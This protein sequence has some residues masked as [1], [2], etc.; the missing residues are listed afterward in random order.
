[1]AITVKHK[2]ISA[3]PDAG[4]PNVVQPSNWNDT[5]EL[6][7][8]GTMA[9]QNANAVAITGG[10]MSGV[11][12]TGYI[13]TT[14]KAQPLGVAT[15]DAS[16]KVPTSQ[17]PMQ[18]DLNY[19]GTWNANT[20]TPTLVS[21]TGTKGYYYVVDVAGTTNLNG[22]TDWQIGDW[23]IFN[24]TIWQK[25]DNTD[26]VSSVNGQTGAVVLT[27]TNIAE[28]TNEYFTTARAR[29]SVSAGTGI[30]YDNGTG[31]ITNSAPDQTVAISD[32][33]G[34]D[35][36][37][38]Y[39]NFT[40]TN[41]APD[42]T[43]VLTGGT[44][45]STS[46][47]YPSFTVTN[48]APDQIVGLTGAGTTVVTGTY[49]NF[50][51][52]STDSKVGD[53]VGPT[54]ATDNAIARYDSTTGKLI[55]NSVVTVS[56]TGA[57][58]G[59]SH[60]TDLD[61]LDFDTTYATPLG[62]GQLG[63]N[64]NDTLGLGMIGGNVVQHIGEDTFF[65]IKASATITKGQ[66]CMFT[67]AVG[68]SGV[69]TAAPATA[70]PYA[71]AILGVAAEDIANN[72]FGLVQNTGTLKGVNTSAFLDGDVL[73]YN[74]AV[75]GGFTKTY[76]ASGP[77]ALVAAVAKSGSGGSGVLTVRVSFQTR[78]TGSTGIS[79]VQGN[80]TVVVTNT[81]PDQ[82]V[83]IT[84]AGGAVVTG[85]YPSFTVTTP[86]GTVTS[87]TGTSPIVS[88]GGA[89][90][91]ISMPAATGSV[92][93]YLTSTDWTTFNNKSNTVGT[94]TSVGGTGTVNGLTLTGT[95][96]SSGNLTLGG[97]LNLSSPPAIGNTTPN[98]VAGTVIQATNG[99]VVNSNTV[100]ASYTIPVG[101]S[102]MSA[103]PMTVASGQA[104]TVSS[105][106]RWVIL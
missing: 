27:T 90:P 85:T 20:N 35:V 98:T 29:T 11:T 37:G 40:V 70:I 78:V 28:G 75:T 2:F 54:S 26:Q 80:D 93:G 105:G 32:G 55:Q 5:H 33:T 62:A 10:T 34:I 9:E 45:I 74:S 48:T 8:L 16:G 4:D 82:V 59:A 63:W 43:V 22:I 101:S 1:M 21:S 41:T 89:T 13:P 81:A 64:G 46:G 69:L 61:Y 73:Y 38:T 19:Q 15:L 99:I 71:E 17:I 94:V 106:S 84:G 14:E 88:S 104:V 72:A 87:V 12:V 56:D 103:G 67:G 92:N 60:I 7:G 39:P 24:G 76:P 65:Y 18:G 50:T 58:D 97:T 31:V 52:T 96:T 36:T 30:S 66:L 77:V 44:A 6:T 51:I 83:S 91:A 3:I 100:S 102:A 23:A 25:V 42:Q 68:S 47:T 49:P 86:S 95:V 79:V 53:V 57:I